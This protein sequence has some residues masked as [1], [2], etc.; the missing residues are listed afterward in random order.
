VNGVNAD[1][2][3]STDIWELNSSGQWMASVS[4]GSHPAGYVVVGVGDFTGNGTSG[5]FCHSAS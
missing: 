5:I 1:G 3:V 4:P 2:T